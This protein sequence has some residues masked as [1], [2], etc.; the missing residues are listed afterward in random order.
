[1]SFAPPLYSPKS[2][3]RA[4]GPSR[5]S[6]VKQSPSPK[7]KMN[8]IARVDTRRAAPPH[9]PR[10]PFATAHSAIERAGSAVA[11]AD[12]KVRTNGRVAAN[13]SPIRQPQPYWQAAAIRRGTSQPPTPLLWAAEAK[14]LEEAAAE[15]VMRSADDD[16]LYELPPPVVTVSLTDEP[17]DATEA[18]AAA[19]ATVELWRERRLRNKPL[20]SGAAAGSASQ[21][22]AAELAGNTD[23]P[24]ERQCECGYTCGTAAAWAKHLGCCPLIHPPPA[25]ETPAPETPAL[26]TQACSTDVSAERQC[27]CGYTCGTAAAWAKHLGCCPLIHPPKEPERP[28]P[29]QST[30][31]TGS[32]PPSSTQRACACGYVASSRAAFAR[33]Q[34]RCPLLGT[35]LTDAAS[36]PES[37][38]PSSSVPSTPLAPLAPAAPSTMRLCECGFTC[39]TE[40]AW[41]RHLGKCVLLNPPDT[42]GPAAAAAADGGTPGQR[43]CECGFSCGTAAAWARHQAKCERCQPA[44]VPPAVPSATAAS[45]LSHAAAAAAASGAAAASRLWRRLWPLS[46][47]PPL[48]PQPPSAQRDE[49]P[50]TEV[51]KA[52]LI[53]AGAAAARQRHRRARQAARAEKAA[54]VK[55]A[56]KAGGARRRLLPAPLLTPGAGR[57]PAAVALCCSVGLLLLLMMM[58]MAPAPSGAA[59]PVE[60]T[61]MA[62]RPPL[63]VLLS[64]DQLGKLRQ[65]AATAPAWTVSTAARV[66]AAA[67]KLGD[68]LGERSAAGLRRAHAR[69]AEGAE[70]AA[71]R[72][73]QM[74][75]RRAGNRTIAE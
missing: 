26:T 54:S 28:T 22:R 21:Q 59:A 70:A 6:P 38:A 47:Q 56:A 32:Q 74:V 18:A 73:S 5:T 55:A 69:L 48:P 62:R 20:D 36:T 49:K 68:K 37:P 44:E 75:S 40:A 43:D 12:A 34:P 53:S 45:S 25:P 64:A 63:A 72:A 61:G 24:G 2:D 60:N 13:R 42:P 31:T 14:A 19:A 8:A 50:A 23:T 33:H 39:G 9:Y 16:A 66:T 52:D 27:E 65:R 58:M 67:G 71:A 57:N 4:S 35:K 46:S 29:A 7:R 1:M 30:P 51:T 11:A 17:A 10:S 15:A 3:R 41:T